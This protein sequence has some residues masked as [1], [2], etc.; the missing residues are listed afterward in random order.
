MSRSLQWRHN[1]HGGVSNYQPHGC[2]HNR[3]FRRIS[4]K[5]QSSASLAFCTGN[6]LEPVNSP[7]K[8]PVTRKMFPFDDVIMIKDSREMWVIY[9]T[10]M[11]ML[12]RLILYHKRQSGDKMSPRWFWIMIDHL[13]G[14]SWQKKI[15][16]I[17]RVCTL[18]YIISLY[19]MWSIPGRF[20]QL[21][22]CISKR[23]ASNSLS[24]VNT[25]DQP[26]TQWPVLQLKRWQW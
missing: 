18:R 10:K 14:L 9:E 3:L 11:Y 26:E 5:H 15:T 24:V 16:S 13:I 7:H 17:L 1:D 6:S 8:G 21:P 23:F 25:I 20:N 19:K 12:G 22:K 2:L 4:K